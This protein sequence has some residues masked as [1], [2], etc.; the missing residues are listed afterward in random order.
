MMDQIDEQTIST[1][2]G[3]RLRAARQAMN[4]SEKDAALRLHL[5]PRIVH[6]IENED[7]T[8]SPP[9]IFMRGY[10]KS[11]ARLLNLSEQDINDALDTLGMNVAPTT[12]L[13]QPTSKSKI[14]DEGRSSGG[15]QWLT[16]LIF[17]ALICLVAVWW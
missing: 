17:G 13:H 3:Q 7:F 4:L 16:Y 14:T 9:T 10:F 12:I 2:I 11:Y 8:N 15:M 1:T 5:N 6:Q